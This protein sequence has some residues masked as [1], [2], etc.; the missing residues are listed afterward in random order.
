MAAKNIKKIVENYN[1][2]GGNDH[3]SLYEAILKEIFQDEMFAEVNDEDRIFSTLIFIRKT[4]FDSDGKYYTPFLQKINS[5]PKTEDIEYYLKF[6]T[7][8]QAK[9]NELLQ[10]EN[11]KSLEELVGL[12]KQHTELTDLLET[13]KTGDVKTLQKEVDDY[14][15]Q[16][17]GKENELKKLQ[18]E[19]KELKVSLEKHTEENDTVFEA[20]RQSDYFKKFT[21]AHNIIA[22]IDAIKSDINNKL[23][24]YDKMIKS[25]VENREKSQN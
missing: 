24:D 3:M 11:I 17:A 12:K 19:L 5:K 25:V 13:L 14:K 10:S 6:V 1:F 22:V 18:N 16:V 20:I 8:T 15:K 23:R 7:E 4:L 21:N 9:V 2:E